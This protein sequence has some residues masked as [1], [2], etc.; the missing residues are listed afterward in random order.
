MPIRIMAKASQT[1]A[2][3]GLAGDIVRVIEKQQK[4]TQRRF[5]ALLVAFEIR[6]ALSRTLRWR[7][8]STGRGFFLS[9]SGGV[10][11]KPE[12]YSVGAYQEDVRESDVFVDERVSSVKFEFGEGSHVAVQRYSVRRVS[13]EAHYKIRKDL[14]TKALTCDPD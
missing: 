10:L 9:D 14:M 2:Y 7:V 12:R 3:Y 1:N 8:Q 11:R 5:T 4:P 13:K 6:S